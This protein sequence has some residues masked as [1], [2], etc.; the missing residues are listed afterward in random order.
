MGGRALTEAAFQRPGEEPEQP[1]DFR[2][3]QI[4]VRQ[5]AGDGRQCPTHPVGPVAEQGRAAQ[6]EDG[7]KNDVGA[8]GYADSLEQI[9]VRP[10]VNEDDQVA[11]GRASQMVDQQ[12][13]PADM[14]FPTSLPR[15]LQRMVEPFRAKR[16]VV[17]DQQQ[18]GFFQPL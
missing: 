10:G 11:G 4:R 3:G 13:I 17:G 8:E 7:G 1:P 12:K 9:S 5:Q 15:A 14:T 16:G 6:V 18:H 2:G